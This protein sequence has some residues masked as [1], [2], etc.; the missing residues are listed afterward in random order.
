MPDDIREK[1]PLLMPVERLVPSLA[2]RVKGLPK[3]G[4]KGVHL[5]LFWRHYTRNDSVHAC[6]R[7]TESIIVNSTVREPSKLNS[8][9]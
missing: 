5:L 1:L 6:R 4:K 7:I 3:R 9:N 8:M 2:S